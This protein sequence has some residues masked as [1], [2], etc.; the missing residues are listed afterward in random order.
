MF[1]PLPLSELVVRISIIRVVRRYDELKPPVTTTTR[2]WEVTWQTP[3]FR[4][5]VSSSRLSKLLLMVHPA[6]ERCGENISPADASSIKYVPSFRKWKLLITS[7]QVTR[8]GCFEKF[9]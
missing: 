2:H 5:F 3:C 1:P 7:V 8:R 6:V 4:H 9:H